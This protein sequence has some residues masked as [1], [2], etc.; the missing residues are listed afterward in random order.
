MYRNSNMNILVHLIKQYVYNRSVSIQ[1]YQ[2]VCPKIL[3]HVHPLDFPE[4]EIRPVWTSYVMLCLLKLFAIMGLN[5][6]QL[7]ITLK[8]YSKKY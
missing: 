4:N 6:E 1:F 7:I 8:G 5:S 2:K 3:L